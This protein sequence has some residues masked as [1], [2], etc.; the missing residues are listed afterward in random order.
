MSSFTK[1]NPFTNQNEYAEGGGPRH[2][3][4]LK[5]K[6]LPSQVA[7]SSGPFAQPL[8]AAN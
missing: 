7:R 8:P 6:P 3:T 2:L 5:N 1:P 4:P